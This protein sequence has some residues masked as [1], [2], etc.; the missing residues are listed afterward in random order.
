MLCLS[1]FANRAFRPLFALFSSFCFLRLAKGTSLAFEHSFEKKKARKRSFRTLLRN[2][3][4]YAGAL[5]APAE[6]PLG[7]VNAGLGAR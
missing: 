7:P 3:F 6:G 4:T 2:L 1:H 5:R